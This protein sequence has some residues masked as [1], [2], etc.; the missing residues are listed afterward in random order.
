MHNTMQAASNPPL[1]SAV[2]VLVRGE[3][4][5]LGHRSPG[6][7]WHFR[8]GANKAG[9][10]EEMW[11]RLTHYSVSLLKEKSSPKYWK[12]THYPQKQLLSSSSLFSNQFVILEPPETPDELSIFTFYVNFS[13]KKL[14]ECGVLRALPV[15][16]NKGGKPDSSGQSQVV[17]VYY[18]MGCTEEEERMCWTSQ[19]YCREQ[20]GGGGVAVDRWRGKRERK[21]SG[22]ERSRLAGAG[23]R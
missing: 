7:K 21:K 9:R 14:N 4:S 3:V 19:Q 6:G 15:H 22:C 13:F 10:I 2:M 17:C 1:A 12:V 16:H 5:Q 18:H 20:G 23:L 8:Q 11:H